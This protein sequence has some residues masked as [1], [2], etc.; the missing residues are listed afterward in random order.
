[1]T[2]FLL[3]SSHPVQ[4]QDFTCPLPRKT[5]PKILTWLLKQSTN[6]SVYDYCAQNDGFILFYSWL[7]TCT[8]IYTYT[9]CIVF[10]LSESQSVNLG[11]SYFVDL[12]R[13]IWATLA[14][15]KGVVIFEQ[16]HW[17]KLPCTAPVKYSHKLS[18]RSIF[19]Q[20]LSEGL[21][22]RTLPSK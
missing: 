18:D 10:G 12:V 4:K 19:R 6:M 15:R 22:L 20:H 17:P 3:T 14:L 13:W 9:I 5:L 1:M 8:F 2:T 16:E 11:E 21:Q 7:F